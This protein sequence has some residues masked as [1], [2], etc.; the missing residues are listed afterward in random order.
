[1]KLHALIFLVLFI[2]LSYSKCPLTGYLTKFYKG[3]CKNDV[4]NRADWI[5]CNWIPCINNLGYLKEKL[6]NPSEYVKTLQLLEDYLK[7][8]CECRKNCKYTLT[9]E[10]HS[11]PQNEVPGKQVFYEI[12]KG[13]CE[14]E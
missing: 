3:E 5:P 14:C 10:K 13:K 8:D 2:N 1:M 9:D 11:L 12:Y 4:T 7:L 6:N